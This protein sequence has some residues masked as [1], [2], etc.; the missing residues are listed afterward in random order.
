LRKPLI[1]NFSIWN[2]IS[3][4]GPAVHRNKG[5]MAYLVEITLL[6]SAMKISICTTVMNRLNHFSKTIHKNLADN[7]QDV[8]F[9]ILDYN[10]EDGLEDWART[11]LADAI[12]SGRLSFYRE[13][14]AKA[15]MPSHSRNICALQ[16]TGEVVCNVDADHFTGR[17]FGELLRRMFKDG[18]KVIACAPD[19][20]QFV[21]GSTHG[22]IALRRN[23]FKALG[24]YDETFVYGWG[25]EDN[26]LFRR[27]KCA[28][29][30]I[31]HFDKKYLNYILHGEKERL[32]K[33]DFT[34]LSGISEELEG[35][36]MSRMAKEG[37]TVLESDKMRSRLIHEA[38]SE[39]NAALKNYV[40][41]REKEWGVAD[42]V[43][44]FTEPCKS[45]AR[46]APLI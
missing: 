13:A 19:I 42:L 8:E 4:I 9:I 6:N 30:K 34:P 23:H 18:S 17:G 7:D 44:N 45:G 3:L 37:R 36:M 29:F 15:W 22:R 16:A 14:T 39:K 25:G 41:N 10:S 5:R 46:T 35:L 20:L 40:V 26:D 2:P 31:K 38:I 43:K 21:N 1:E 12:A 33:V 11:N 32:Q 27:C 24:G 28:G